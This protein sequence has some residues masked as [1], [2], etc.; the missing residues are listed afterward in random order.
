MMRK[1]SESALQ[2]EPFVVN[3]KKS[4]PTQYMVAKY[5]YTNIGT[6]P[7]QQF[8]AKNEGG[9]YEEPVAPQTLRNKHFT[10]LDCIPPKNKPPGVREFQVVWVLLKK[11]PHLMLQLP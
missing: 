1:S 6:S 9:S 2:K 7:K 3:P 8:S 5:E 10:M 11:K 4:L